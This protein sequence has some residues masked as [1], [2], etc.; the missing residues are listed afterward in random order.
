MTDRDHHVLDLL[1]YHRVLTTD[2]IQAAAFDSVVAAR[3][4]M[5]TLHGLGVVA[6]FRP[7]PE[8]GSA[9]WHY[10]LDTMGAI[11]RAARTGS[12]D[13]LAH[14]SRFRRDRQLAIAHSSHLD[15]LVTVN[16]FFTALLGTART[17][18]GRCELRTWWNEAGSA[19][20]VA[21]S[22]TMNFGYAAWKASLVRPDGLGIWHED[23]YRVRFLVEVD[24][25]TEPLKRLRDKL[26][27]YEGLADDLGSS[28]PWVLFAF[29][30][31][32][33]E[34]NARS[35]LGR[36]QSARRVPVATAHRDQTAEPAEAVWSPLTGDTS[37][38]RLAHLAL[39]RPPAVSRSEAP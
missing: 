12:E 5:A 6:R 19:Q 15:H 28:M 36:H 7:R 11:V 27:R 20:W 30:T 26:V 8:R 31:A 33:R 34:S 25:G 29:P 37:Q 35:T 21:D 17:S 18:D 10:V 39:S 13:A 22:L 14:A 23:E 3:H 16:G 38:R 1:D 4:R 24:T 2:H 32:K 9:P